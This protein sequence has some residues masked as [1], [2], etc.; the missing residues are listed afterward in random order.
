MPF[1]R[2]PLPPQVPFVLATRA[3]PPLPLARLR[4]GGHLLEVPAA[5]LRFSLEE[6]SAFLQTVRGLAL[7]PKAIEA[8]ESRTEGWIAGLQLSAL[9]LQRRAAFS[10]FRAPSSD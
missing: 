10:T 6:A 8:L 1:L 4:A 2:D 5:D 7:P 3:D 9:S